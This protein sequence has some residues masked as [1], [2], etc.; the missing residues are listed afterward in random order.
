MTNKRE[1]VYL[2]SPY[3]CN[4]DGKEFGDGYE[5]KMIQNMRFMQVCHA[6]CAMMHQG[7][8]VYSPIAHTVP[9]ARFGLPD[10]YEFWREYDHEI[11]RRMDKL[12]VLM[13]DGWETSV[14][15]Q[16][17][18]A[19]MTELGKPVEYLELHDVIGTITP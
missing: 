14:G 4:K 8:F 6:A 11:L 1:F 5:R 12:V 2:A 10:G 16:D 3:T 9:I 17:E 7:I 13:L 19:F 15:V 18:I